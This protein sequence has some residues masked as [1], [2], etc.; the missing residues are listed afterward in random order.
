MAEHPDTYELVRLKITTG[1]A[2]AEFITYLINEEVAR[3]HGQ[4]LTYGGVGLR[5]MAHDHEDMAE[6]LSRVRDDLRRQITAPAPSTAPK[7]DA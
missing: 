3:L 1:R 2:A 4:G 7:D 5:V 6:T